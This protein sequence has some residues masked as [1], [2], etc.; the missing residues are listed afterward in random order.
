MDHDSKI[1]V[2]GGL[3]FIGSVLYQMLKEEGF[4]SV[5]VLDVNLYHRAPL[6]KYVNCDI[7]NKS[8]LDKVIP[9]YDI[10]ISMASIVGD[11]ACLESHELSLGVNYF[12]IRNLAEVCKE[13]NKKILHFSTC[14]VYGS[15]FNCLLKE[16]D[17]G[18][19]IDFY[20]QLKYS[21]E[22]LIQGIY[23]I[24]GNYIIVRLGTAYGLSPVMRYDLVVNRFVAQAVTDKKISV[25]GG[26]QERPFVH[27]RDISR[28]VIH[29][30]TKG[31]KGIFNIKGENMSINGIA[32][33]IKEKID[34]NIIVE[35]IFDKRNYNI[36]DGKLKKTGFEYLHNLDYAIEEISKSETTKKYFSPEYCNKDLVS[37]I[38]NV[39]ELEPKII[40]CGK[41]VDD[42]GSLTFCNDFSFSSKI[43]RFYQVEN[44]TVDVIRAIHGHLR[45]AKYVRVVKG[46]MLIVLTRL[47]SPTEIETTPDKVKKYILSSDK[48]SILYIPPG[49]A[50]GFRFL[51]ED[52]TA[53]FYS[54]ST[55]KESSEDD[56]RF[57]WDTLGKEIF[58]ITNR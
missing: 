44:N 43:K 55:L 36:D 2:V 35:P 48:P 41:A 12:G 58:Q 30:L 19:P 53:I 54:T 31:E 6:V 17:E 24:D 4:T 27:I 46:S 7:R 16:D 15:R 22:K 40:E 51:K 56:F 11:P 38:K 10:I 28:A 34:C 42:R 32:K 57:P 25:Y 1:L 3:G 50:N 14:S 52:T 9:R 8:E 33:R 23:G 39:S 29:L 13:Y 18:I 47:I 21:Q 20:G 5:D 37:M 45:E 49:Y 26:D